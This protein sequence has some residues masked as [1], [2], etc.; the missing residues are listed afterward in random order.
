M[1][2]YVYA[3]HFSQQIVYHSSEKQEFDTNS[4]RYFPYVPLLVY[5]SNLELLSVT[6]SKKIFNMFVTFLFR[7][8]VL[9][10][11]LYFTLTSS[12]NLKQMPE[13]L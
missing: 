12:E 13:H 10:S 5:T 2:I 9:S 6:V 3:R 11:F 7:F 8:S 1:I 4:R